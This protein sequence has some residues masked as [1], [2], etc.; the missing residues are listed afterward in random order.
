MSFKKATHVGLISDSKR[1]T[2]LRIE[3]ISDNITEMNKRLLRIEQFQANILDKLT[4]L[5]EIIDNKKE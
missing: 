4:V 2:V 5:A 1:D 3:D